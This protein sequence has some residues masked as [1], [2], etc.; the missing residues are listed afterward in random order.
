MIATTKVST[1]HH[2]R[3]VPHVDDLASTA[4]LIGSASGAELRPRLDAA[5]TFL[6]S[7]LIPHMEAA[8]RAIYPELERLLQN[9]HSMTP[10]RRE[11]AEIRA[12]IADLDGLRLGIG[13]GAVSTGNAVA[14]RR[15]LYRLHGLL[16]V[17]LAEEQLYANIVESGL[18]P[19][20]EAGLAAAMAHEGTG[21][22]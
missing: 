15:A 3:L 20:A 4:E 19:E 17:H 5:C 13:D 1:E 11:H 7:L 21:T 16:K 10:M 12:L 8:E 6:T 2:A 9:R 14:L 18:S 22:F